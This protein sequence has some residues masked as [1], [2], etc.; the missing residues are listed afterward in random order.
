MAGAINLID[1][2]QSQSVL[3]KITKDDSGYFYHRLRWFDID[4]DGLMDIFTCRATKPIFSSGKGEL[5][6]L[7]QPSSNPLG[8][9]WPTYYISDGCDFL[10]EA[11]DLDNDGVPEIIAAEFFAQQL[12]VFYTTDGKWTDSSS[13]VKRVLDT[14]VG[15][16][17]DVKVYSRDLSG[18]ITSIVLSNHMGDGTGSVWIFQVPVDWKTAPWTRITVAN[19]FKIREPGYNQ[20]APGSPEPFYPKAGMSGNKWLALSGDGAQYAYQL[21]PDDGLNFTRSDLV[22]A[23]ATVGQLAV[24]DVDQDGYTELFVP[25]YDTGVVYVYSY[26]P[27]FSSVRLSDRLV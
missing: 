19:G 15:P 2:S 25:A 9:S 8:T 27:K 16:A 18:R 11:M 20:A 12:T 17:F 4:S 21:A 22:N 23:A 1:T 26:N 13:I 14:T 3:H 7:K 6:W 5:V 24:E 10:W